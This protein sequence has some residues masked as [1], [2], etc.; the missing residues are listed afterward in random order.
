MEGSQV[1][2]VGERARDGT[3]EVVVGEV[4]VGEGSKLWK[5]ERDSA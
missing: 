2:E 1:A 3:G 4:K 5:P